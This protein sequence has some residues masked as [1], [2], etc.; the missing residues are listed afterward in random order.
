M[1]DKIWQFP[2]VCTQ[3]EHQSRLFV[4]FTEFGIKTGLAPS[5]SVFFQILKNFMF[6][7]GKYTRKRGLCKVKCAFGAFWRGFMRAKSGYG[8][9]R[10]VFCGFLDLL[11]TKKPPCVN[12]TSKRSKKKYFLGT[13][14]DF[15][16]NFR[17]AQALRKIQLSKRNFKAF[18]AFN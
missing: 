17:T 2:W 7:G 8:P 6:L 13:T 15:R 16:S 14:L 11:T 10:R 9:L 12:S 3:D 5:V 18:H 4:I 1:S